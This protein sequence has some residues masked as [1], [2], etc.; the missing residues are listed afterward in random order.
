MATA[1]GGRGLALMES[2]MD[3]VDV[4]TADDMTTVRLRRRY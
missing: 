3:D 1:E 2:L 4:Q